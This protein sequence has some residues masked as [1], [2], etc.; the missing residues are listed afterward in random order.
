MR[1]D[2]LHL[3]Q[4]EKK[5]IK[6][7]REINY[8]GL[9][10]YFKKELD[11]MISPNF[12]GTKLLNLKMQKQLCEWLSKGKFKKWSLTFRAT[13]DGFQ[14]FRKKVLP[15]RESVIIIQSSNGNIFG[16]FFFLLM[17]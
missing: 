10:E 17:N 3:P 5:F 14:N 7:I 1:T 13:Q 16:G 9:G 6:L 15:G 8:Y 12:A 11:V 4:E 2:V